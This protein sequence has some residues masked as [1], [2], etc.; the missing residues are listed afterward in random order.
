M[1]Q[2]SLLCAD[3]PLRN[4]THSHSRAFPYHNPGTQV[5][6]VMSQHCDTATTTNCGHQ[7]PHDF[8]GPV[9]YVL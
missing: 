1:A 6:A 2:N 9:K 4:Y 5:V 8:M 3:V 7:P